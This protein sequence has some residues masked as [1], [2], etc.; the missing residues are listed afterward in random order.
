MW[1]WLL[2]TLAITVPAAQ[3]PVAPAPATTA[4]E[5]RDLGRD[6]RLGGHTLQRHIGRT[7]EQLLDR[8]RRE[9]Q[10]SAASTYNDRETAE[11]VIAQALTR[12]R[13]RVEQWLG[14]R[15]P[16]PNLALNYHDPGPAP[17]GRSMM[18]RT[19][20]PVPCSDVIVV[21]RWDGRSG[22]YVLTSY[23]EAPR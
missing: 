19:R 10:I 3:A 22:Y 13:S 18:R 17:I 15:G 14:R 7:D 9:P 21:L 4:A 1:V 20:R 23:P 2:L 6:E 5:L 8:L 12:N 16:R 11:R